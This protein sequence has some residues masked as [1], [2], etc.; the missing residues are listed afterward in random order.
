[1]HTPREML[2]RVMVSKDI[3]RYSRSL[4][5]ST[6]KYR[7]FLQLLLL[8]A[9]AIAVGT[10]ATLHT[11]GMSQPALGPAPATQKRVQTPLPRTNP[12]S[13]ANIQKAMQTLGRPAEILLPPA[14]ALPLRPIDPLPSPS[15]TPFP[16]PTPPPIDPADRVYTYLRFDPSGVSETL[17]T[18]LEADETIQIMDFP[19]ANPELYSD[20]FA[21]DEAKA[22]LLRDGW[23]YAV[24][25]KVSPLVNVLKT[26]PGLRTT[27]LNELY[28]PNDD[29]TELQLQALREAGYSDDAVQKFAICLF[30]R[31]SGF[32][33]Y[34]DNYY[35]RLEPVRGMQV[36]GLVFGIPLHTF[37]DANGHYSFP[38]RFSAGTIMGTHAKNSRV[39]VKPL[40]THGTLIQVI[41]QLIAN[42]IFGSIHIRGWVSSC[43][44][45]N[46]VNFDFY[47]HTQARYWSQLLN[48]VY[49]HDVYSQ[50][51]GIQSAPTNNL[52]VYAQWANG[53]D[54]GN[55]STPMLYHLTGGA[56][57][58]TFLGTLFDFSPTGAI[59][60]LLHGLL[61]DMTF[62]V[63]G[64]AEPILYETRLAQTAFHELGHGSHFRRVNGDYW[65]DVIHA[66][67]FNGGCPGYGCGTQTDAGNLQVAESWAEYIG[68]QNALNRYP[69]GQIFSVS[70]GQWIR[71]DE[72]LEREFTFFNNWIPTG[73]YNDLRDVG[74]PFP[75]FPEAFDRTGGAS[76]LQLYN[77]FN[78][79]V[80][81]MCKYQEE[82]LRQNPGFFRGDVQ[83]IFGAHGITGCAVTTGGRH[84]GMTWSVLQQGPAGVIRVGTDAVTNP[85]GGDTPPTTQLPVLCLLVNNSPVPPGITPDFYNGWARGPVAITAPVF[86]SQLT[87]PAAADAI[88]SGTFGP[89]WRMAEFHDG[90]FGP[91]LAQS[92]G[93]SYWAFGGLPLGTRFWTAI[94]DQPA[95]PWN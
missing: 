38:W 8:S 42:F 64:N 18:Q 87:S 83:D 37:T 89:G 29:D 35:G 28:L 55:A 76:I 48:A 71:L 84:L 12:F 90:W 86:G 16:S 95:N 31:P 66:T 23:L 46:D 68:K 92:G 94:N 5:T 22:E 25:K 72:G 81:T 17:M 79:D 88:C 9:A 7:L 43:T 2:S 24:L 52:I 44:M 14:P 30:K 13:L 33:R 50:Q 51:Q 10:A 67:V 74:N 3:R 32:V 82:F 70:L 36:W 4:R 54:F 40:N 39:N 91:N 61:P 62:R 77:V 80:D 49:F 47:G 15:P 27:E 34:W 59:L 63:S 19:F 6:H 26:D 58:D 41:P 53:S 1:M 75:A 60:S 21:L 78:S 20:E 11:R 93:W 73:I 56:F 69:N 45:R 65:W 57:T 85:Y